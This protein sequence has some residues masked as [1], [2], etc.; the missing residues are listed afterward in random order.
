MKNQNTKRDI[1]DEL[2]TSPS[3]DTHDIL[4]EISSVWSDDVLDQILYTDLKDTQEEIESEEINMWEF[5]IETQDSKDILQQ[6]G[7]IEIYDTQ[8]VL[9]NYTPQWNLDKEK[10]S[11]L[12]NILSG[13]W[14]FTKYILTSSFIFI[15]LMAGVN[16]SAYIE[17]ARSYFNPE[18]FEANKESMLASIQSTQI[19]SLKAEVRE[20]ETKEQKETI[21]QKNS[22]QNSFVEKPT[23]GTIEMAQNKTFHSME[24]LINT[25]TQW[26]HIDIEMVPYENRIVIPKLGKNIPLID[27][28]NKTV[29]NVGELDSIFMQELINGIV[30]YPGSALPWEIGNSFIFW[31]S[32]NFPWLEG[33]YNDVF[34]LLDNL[35]FWDEI[36][37][38]YWQKKY[39]YKITQKSVIKPWDT[40]ILKRNNNK[41]EI[42]L[43]TCWPVGTTL[44]RMIVIWELIE[45]DI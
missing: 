14:L 42:T 12:N 27:V 10:K 9:K 33:K 26:V 11:S 1:L 40:D 34:A 2:F 45:Q 8:D 15:V 38:Y 35:T 7:N 23:Q 41:A 17:I 44:N 24:K 28:K 25:S 32:S 30:R 3:K 39:I 20:E 19:S 22:L 13:W 29:K 37:A 5:F 31:H 43:M 6:V 4:S 36:I 21:T 16:Y 18:I